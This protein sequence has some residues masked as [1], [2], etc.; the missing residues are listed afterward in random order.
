M[1]LVGRGHPAIRATHAKT[2]EFTSDDEITAR[3]TCIVAVAVEVAPRRPDGPVPAPLAG[4]VRI[5]IHAG[6]EAYAL[7]ADANSS[8]NPVGPAVVRRGPLRLP[9]TFAVNATASAADLPRQLVT[10]LQDPSVAVH[11]TVEP[12][13]G[14]PSVVLFAADPVTTTDGR[15]A[16]EIAAADVLV[17]E[18]DAAR[19]LVCA[20][21]ARSKLGR[22]QPT[23][24]VLVV[25]TDALPGRSVAIGGRTLETVGLS[26][27]LTAAAALPGGAKITLAGRSHPDQ[28][29]TLRRTPIDHRLVVATHT[30]SLRT[31]LAQAREIRGCSTAVVAQPYADPV[32]VETAG[33]SRLD[34]PG[35]S[36]VWVG[37]G[38]G[39]ADLDL[40][41]PIRA[42]IAG[43]LADG[44]ATKPAARALAALTGWPQRATYDRVVEM[45]KPR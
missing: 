18:D 36:E 9:G 44:V 3:A 23:G 16:A 20:A 7:D 45:S 32:V 25:A 17:A 43:L 35:A 6:A 4:P 15:L 33:D 42:A 34:F 28:R 31:L 40:E 27:Q 22:D 10:A 41:P 29:E 37:F 11:I 38:A 1:R 8:W 24:R 5:S 30:R 2:L 26:A 39:D 12:R 13:P 19:A 14:P 21:D